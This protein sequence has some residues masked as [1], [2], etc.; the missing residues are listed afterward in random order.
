MDCKQESSSD[1]K[2]LWWG[3]ALMN[4]LAWYLIFSGASAAWNGD[5][6]AFAYGFSGCFLLA[7]FYHPFNAVEKEL[8]CNRGE[9]IICSRF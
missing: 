6:T 5:L 7:F 8:R 4:A 9:K 1:L 2:R 3:F